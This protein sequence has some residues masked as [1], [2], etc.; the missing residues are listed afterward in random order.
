MKKL[1]I[2]LREILIH[3]MII[4][5]NAPFNP[6]YVDLHNICE[7]YQI[8]GKKP[9]TAFIGPSHG[10]KAFLFSEQLDIIF[11]DFTA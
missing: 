7:H 6:K 10:K 11:K 9:C 4:K 3:S 1:N 2:S 5:K 8:A